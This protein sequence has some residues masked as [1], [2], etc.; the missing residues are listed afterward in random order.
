MIW[1]DDF[2][3]EKAYLD[4]KINLMCSNYFRLNLAGE[5]DELLSYSRNE[6]TTVL[7]LSHPDPA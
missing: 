1:V 7:P 2:F 6:I 4:E 5:S 3:T